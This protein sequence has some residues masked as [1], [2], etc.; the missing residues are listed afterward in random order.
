MY[1]LDLARKRKHSDESEDENTPNK[2][3]AKKESDEAKSDIKSKL[4]LFAHKDQ[5]NVGKAEGQ[6][7]DTNSK[8]KKEKKNVKPKKEKNISKEEVSEDLNENSNEKKDVSKFQG[9]LKM[10]FKKSK[11]SKDKDGV[12]NQDEDS[13]DLELVLESSA[14][15]VEKSGNLNITE[16]KVSILSVYLLNYKIRCQHQQ[17]DR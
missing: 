11:K 8:S 3:A 10:P 4:A 7:T 12:S 13:V 9:L 16:G 1:N 17:H 14:E 15:D 5:E 2:K 6:S